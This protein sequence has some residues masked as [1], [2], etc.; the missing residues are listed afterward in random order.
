MVLCKI[1][2]KSLLAVSNIHLEKHSTTVQKYQKRFGRNSIGTLFQVGQLAHNDP[3]YIKWRK[4]L[5]NRPAP[6]SKGFTKETHP[7]VAK[8]SET[9][10]RKK[11]DNFR[12]WREQARQ[13]G[14]IPLSYP[15]FKRTEKL[16]FLIGMVLGDGS[17]HKFPRAEG[18][19]ISLGTD[20]PKLWKYTA[21]VVKEVFQKEPYVYKVKRS[22]CM[23]ISLYQKE[24]SKRLGI[25]Q[26]RRSAL[27]IA[28]PNWISKNKVMLIA[29]L[30][31]LYEA[32]G[33]FNIHKPTST[34]KL[35]FSN[36]N[37]TLLKIVESS[38]RRL[39]FHP[40]VSKYK[41]QV[42]RKDEVYR[43]KNLFSFREY[44]TT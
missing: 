36:R 10:R 9:F 22:A 1:C 40:H 35:I 25:P 27:K 12:Q 29:Y 38:V 15:S 11:I 7:S 26:G 28:L 5:L 16:A 3:R 33:S 14:L 30:K 42:S 4:S 39:G 23:N 31:G 6:W 19:R 32:E 18:L 44:P 2:G 17:I 20:K 37:D 24:I 13:K 21:Q 41:V 43:L 8:I 34:Y